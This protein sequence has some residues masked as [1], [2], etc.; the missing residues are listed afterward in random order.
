[1]KLAIAIGRPARLL[2]RRPPALVHFMK[3]TLLVSVITLAFLTGACEKQSYTETR[4]F[5]HH[6]SH[7]VEAAGAHK[8]EGAGGAPHEKPAT[9]KPAAH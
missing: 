5:T 1:M 9:E 8:P 2:G 6:G 4:A 7:G 3:V